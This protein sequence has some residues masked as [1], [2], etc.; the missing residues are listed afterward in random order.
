MIAVV[1]IVRAKRTVQ[2]FFPVGSRRL[3]VRTDRP[4]ASRVCRLSAGDKGPFVPFRPAPGVV[5]SPMLARSK[6]E[7]RAPC[8]GPSRTW[9]GIRLWR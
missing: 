2:S 8:Q 7:R 1:R 6:T 9:L 4:A 3:M 5:A